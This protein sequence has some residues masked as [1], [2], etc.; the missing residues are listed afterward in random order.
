M[1]LVVTVD[2]EADNQ[3]DMGRPLTT[4]NVHYLRPFQSVCDAY[5]ITP[6]YLLT[7]EMAADPA[8]RELLTR[9]ISLGKAEVGAH[10]HPWTT[11]PYSDEPGFRFN[12]PAHA[13]PSELPTE[14]L[15][16]KLESL[17]V[18]I[19]R[20]FDVR[21]SSFRAGRFG[22]DSR[23]AVA[24]AELGYVVDASLTPLAR[25][26]AHQGLPDS[27]G[28]PDFTQHEA[29]PFVIEGTPAP[30]LLELPVTIV[31]TYA[32]LRRYPVLYR[33][34]RS[35]PMRP[36]R[37]RLFRRWLRPAPVWLYPTP[38]STQADLA[39]ALKE[40]QR[41]GSGAAVMMLHSSELMP[42]CSPFRTTATSVGELLDTLDG[43]FRHAA[44]S[45]VRPA[46]LSAAAREIS[47]SGSLNV[48]P[49]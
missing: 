1:L 18:E 2:T 6:T 37:N 38:G 45:G 26:G 19:E 9:W 16:Q 12:D 30:G 29:L 5:G 49:L 46:T 42:G 28:G 32:L 15:R 41:M 11:P 39:A 14:L 40:C 35:F 36:A 43:F 17:T 10:L 20:G 27:Q 8:A 23:C 44:E 34:Y 21:P 13:Y 25:W 22:F 48:R 3:W 33:W 24:L 31:T 7:S 47:A 4:E